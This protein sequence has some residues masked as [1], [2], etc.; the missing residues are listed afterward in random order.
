MKRLLAILVLSAATP[1]WAGVSV[2]DD[3]GTPCGD[4][5][6]A[7]AQI[8]NVGPSS[9]LTYGMSG[10][11][12]TTTALYGCAIEAGASA[13]FKVARVCWG[14][15]SATA[16]AGV[17]VK[18]FRTTAAS[19]GGT[20]ATNEGTGAVAISKYDPAAGNWPGVGRAGGI[21]TTAGATLFQWSYMVGEIGAGTAD[22]GGQP[23]HCYEFGKNGTQMPSVVAGTANGAAITITSLGAGGLAFGSCAIEVIQE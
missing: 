23:A 12:L 13:A 6:A 3:G 1:T 10:S 21:T 15:T 16:A 19:S 8:T 22:P 4:V 18:F 7:K 20:A 5:N 17:T 14:A 2:C 11:A 9:R